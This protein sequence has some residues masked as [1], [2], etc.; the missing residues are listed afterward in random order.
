MRDLLKSGV[1]QDIVGVARI[2]YFMNSR[3]PLGTID[4]QLF[5]QGK[6]FIAGELALASELE[7]EQAKIEVEN[8]LMAMFHTEPEPEATAGS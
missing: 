3:R 6:D 2:L 4:R 1:F 5:D 8:Q 7:I